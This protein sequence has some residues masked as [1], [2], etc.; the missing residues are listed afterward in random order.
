MPS[1]VEIANAAL[2]K[3]GEPP[4][5]SFEDAEQGAIL[6]NNTFTIYRDALIR[7]HPWKFAT[8]R[9]ALATSTSTPAWEFTYSYPVPAEPYYFLKL[10]TIENPSDY[11]YRLEGRA[12]VTDLGA[13]LYIKYLWRVS[14]PNQWD[15]LFTEAFVAKLAWEWAEN[16]TKEAELRQ[17]LLKEFIG[18]IEQAFSVDGQEGKTEPIP[19]GTWLGAHV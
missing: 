8:R 14:D 11:D 7:A 9:V 18:K 5:T 12:I 3:I 13:P 2:L 16:I 10:L 4:I 6:A 15:T 1:Q 19:D 17:S